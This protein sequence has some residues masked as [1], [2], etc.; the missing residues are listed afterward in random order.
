MT[1]QRQIRYPSFSG[2]SAASP[3][4]SKAK[5]ANRATGTAP[6]LE[7]LAALRRLGL[8]FRIHHPAVV[9]RPDVVFYRTK[10]A[11]FCDGDFWH[12]RHWKRLRPLLERRA[13]AE[14][15]VAKI[16]ANRR[17]DVQITRELRQSGWN[18]LR[19]WEGDVR[20]NVNR[21]ANE[22]ADALRHHRD[23]GGSLGAAK[24]SACHPR[25]I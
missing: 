22:I 11:V 6:E 9:G 8:R 21:V 4:T 23:N 10:I 3:A 19:F 14:Y 17:R 13:N 20:R 18:V 15:W 7:L 16:A 1:R 25:S 5:K 24:E 12:G 2:L